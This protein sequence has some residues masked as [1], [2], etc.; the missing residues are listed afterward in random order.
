M[1]KEEIQE[2]VVTWSP[3]GESVSR[4]KEWSIAMN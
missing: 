1:T 2:N 4:E 3:E